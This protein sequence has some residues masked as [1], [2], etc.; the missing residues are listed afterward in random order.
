MVVSP[1]LRAWVERPPFGTASVPEFLAILALAAALAE[2]LSLSSFGD[3]GPPAYLVLPVVFWAALRAGRRGTTTV[4]LL[5]TVIGIRDTAAGHGPFL[6]IT[7]TRTGISLIVF[8]L[9]ISMSGLAFASL[10]L[11]RDRAEER[12]RESEERFR[13]LIE[14]SSDVVSILDAEGRVRYESPSSLAILGYRPEELVGVDAF[15]FLHPDDV[16]ASRAAF[17]GVFAGPGT[18]IV[19]GARFLHRDGHWVDLV[20]TVRNLLDDPAVGGIV[21]N[22]RDATESKRAERDL[23]EAER[24][25][26]TLVERLP[27]VTYINGPLPGGAPRYVSPQ[28]EQMLGYPASAWYDDARFAYRLIHPDDL[29][30]LER[31]F[32]EDSE[33]SRRAEYRMVA[34]DGRIVWVLDHMVTIR[35]ADGEPALV[36]G[37]LMDITERRRLEEQLAG[38]QRMEALGLLAGGVAHDFNNLLTAIAGYGELARA[39][40]DEPARARDDLDEVLRAAG[41]ASDLTRQLLAFGRRQMLEHQVV[42][43]NT[44]VEETRPLL[45]RLLGDAVRLECR[46]DPAL[47]TVRADAGQLGQ[48][49]VNLAVNAR[50]AMP[51]GGTLTIATGNELVVESGGEV[52]P[53][54]YVSVSV[55]DTGSGIDP[56][57][58]DRLFE[59][60]FTTKEVGKGTGLGL[61]VVFGIVEQ[62]RGRVS[63]RS[64]PGH[65][66]EFRILLPRTAERPN[67][68]AHA[69]PQA[70]RGNETVLLVED[71]DMVRRLTGE[72]LERQGYRVIS[73]A[74]P[75]EALRVEQ[76]YEL[77][78]TDVVMPGMTGPELAEQLAGTSVPRSRCSSPRA[79][80]APPSPTGNCSP[81][82]CSRSRSRSISSHERCGTR[83]TPGSRRAR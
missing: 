35:D 76:P 66:A 70:P 72:M 69:A 10:S 11:V 18:T 3:T 12:L 2:A 14:K 52:P 67:G 34:A 42:D 51:A 83:S 63:V 59:P 48:V 49:L 27:L 30:M 75:A 64:D 71:E 79:T 55:A 29:P 45:E 38:A 73:A 43:L 46:L 61:A 47:A 26:R 58:R 23:A 77:L 7:P 33:D 20:A 9:V 6:A 28:I 37:F 62:S 25:Y 8:L 36:Q 80:P 32:V 17:A 5:V 24:R 78:L 54:E 53:G 1:F 15:D 4:V 21:V 50:D 74:S 19:H 68:R 40:L 65:G 31:L 57:V 22:S 60:F 44:V 39:R 41:R 81:S 56:A 82:G 16:D 13:S